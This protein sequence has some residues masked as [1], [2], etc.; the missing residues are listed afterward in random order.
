MKNFIMRQFTSKKLLSVTDILKILLIFV[1]KCF[2]INF[3]LPKKIYQTIEKKQ[4][5]II[6]PFLGHFSFESRNR[7]NSCIK[8][9]SCILI[10]NPSI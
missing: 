10:K 3:I 5:L 6:L 7:L 9:Q 2:L 8:N 1:L 4:L